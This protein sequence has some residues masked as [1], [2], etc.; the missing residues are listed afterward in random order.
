MPKSKA[1]GPS[2]LFASVQQSVCDKLLDSVD[3]PF[4]AF[5]RNEPFPGCS[6]LAGTDAYEYSD[7]EKR[8]MLK[9]AVTDI[10]RRAK[11]TDVT[12]HD[13]IYAF[14]GSII[15]QAKQVLDVANSGNKDYEGPE[16]AELQAIVDG[17]IEGLV[18]TL[19]DWGLYAHCPYARVI[20][21]QRPGIT[22]H[23]PRIDLTGI[24]VEV[25][26]TG[27]LWAKYPWWHCYKW[28]FKWEK[29]IKCVRIG[30]IT[31]SPD[32]TAEAHADV[33]AD[34]TRVYV[35]GEFDKLRLNYAILDKIPL[36][37]IA[38]RALRDQLVYVYNAAKIV[39]TV[40]VLESR[41]TVDSIALPRSSDGISV[42]V[43]MKEV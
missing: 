21:K 22:L 12:I 31:V 36:E 11:R 34:G 42:E 25:T 4:K 23:S 38:N 16:T 18:D 10:R 33:E 5:E 17:G 37:G 41:F 32:I 39:E 26:A 7:D 14:A 8:A 13:E 40:P 27:E 29:V 19:G 43:V 6:R 28:C 9:A 15:E 2:D 35:R 1:A 30:S 20:V 3:Y 24:N